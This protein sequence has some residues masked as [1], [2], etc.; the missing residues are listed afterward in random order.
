MFRLK[1]KLKTTYIMPIPVYGMTAL[2]PYIMAYV[3][4]KWLIRQNVRSFYFELKIENKSI[5][6]SI[7]DHNLV[8]TVLYLVMKTL[9]W[10]HCG[11]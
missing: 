3:I 4:L 10:P 5:S 9:N 6:T 8:Y 2:F 11:Q 1:K 7:P